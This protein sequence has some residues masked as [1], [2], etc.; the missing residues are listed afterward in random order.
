MFLSYFSALFKDIFEQL[1]KIA[2]LNYLNLKFTDV[3]H[4]T[5][6]NSQKTISSIARNTRAK[7]N[8]SLEVI[9]SKCYNFLKL[10]DCCPET[11][12][13][14]SHYSLQTFLK[15]LKINYIE[16][17]KLLMVTFSKTS[18]FPIFDF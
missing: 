8:K 15:K 9:V 11:L 17:N 18:F 5:R 7:K 12:L 14:L 10:I 4:E 13:N 3:V 16:D 2:P 1:N 6:P